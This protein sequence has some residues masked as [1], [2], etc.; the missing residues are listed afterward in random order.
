MP[1]PYC[2]ILKAVQWN[3]GS[4]EMSPATTLVLPTLRECPPMI[5]IAMVRSYCGVKRNQKFAGEAPALLSRQSRQHRQFFQVV[6]NRTSR[7]SPE[8][9]SFAADH[10]FAGN[11]T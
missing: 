9:D 11:P 10:L 1:C 6:A 5:T 2:V 4:A 8:H 3:C 7:S